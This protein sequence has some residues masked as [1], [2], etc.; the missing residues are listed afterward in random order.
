[1]SN[2]MKNVETVNSVVRTLLVFTIVGGIGAAS[3]FGYSTYQANQNMGQTLGKT[4][5]ELNTARSELEV[6]T[7]QLVQKSNELIQ[8]EEMLVEKDGQIEDLN[9]EIFE[10]DE[11]IVKL[12]TAI[13]LLKVDHRLARIKIVEQ[14]MN[15][16]TKRPFTIVEFQEVNDENQP[17]DDPKR[18]TLKGDTVYVDTWV[19]KF[20]DRYIEEADILRSTSM[21]MFKTIYGNIDG[22]EG[23]Y[24]LEKEGTR[25]KAY[26]RGTKL[27]D[28]EKKI[29]DDFWTIANSPD[30]AKNLGIRAIHGETNFI[31]AVPGKV[32][33]IELRSSGGITTKPGEDLPSP[34]RS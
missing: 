6:K 15:A 12:D 5:E 22:P 23:G 10:K 19:V 28:F 1:M 21:C 18:F 4:Q 25:P 3:W 2:L 14:G 31:K 9:V 34:N 27:N 13:R 24:K 17:I 29:W 8:K 33:K 26:G 32:Y 16:E 20:E 11:K 7:H 30:Q